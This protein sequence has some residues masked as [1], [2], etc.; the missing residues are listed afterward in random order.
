MKFIYL[1]IENNFFIL[2]I[3]ESS[4]IKMKYRI[5]KDESNPNRKNL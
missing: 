2:R 1:R 5:K 3:T 4:P